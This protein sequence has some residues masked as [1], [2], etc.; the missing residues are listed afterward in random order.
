MVLP[1]CKKEILERAGN[2][3]ILLK[4]VLDLKISDIVLPTCVDVRN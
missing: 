2:L 1:K 4:I 3:G